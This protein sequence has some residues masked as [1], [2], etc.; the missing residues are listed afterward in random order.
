M[1]IQ[2]RNTMKYLATKGQLLATLA[3]IAA[4]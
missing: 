4:A 2:I 3:T 1:G